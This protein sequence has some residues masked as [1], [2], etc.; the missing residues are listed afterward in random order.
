[1]FIGH[2]GICGEL[3]KLPL[4]QGQDITIS[5]D[6]IPNISRYTYFVVDEFHY[7]VMD[8]VYFVYLLKH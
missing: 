3:A 5:R 1:M 7:S 6:H 8:A 4:F 2:E